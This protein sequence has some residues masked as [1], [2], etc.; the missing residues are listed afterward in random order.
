MRKI[1]DK[2]L[3]RILCALLSILVVD[4]LWQVASRYILA[5]PSSVT[6]EIAGFLLVWVGLFGAAYC[7]GQGEHLA[8]DIL[9][10]YISDKMKRRLD[11]FINVVVML[12]ALT[13]MT[14][15]GVWL[16]YTR[17]SLGVTS[18][19]LMLNLG[20]V[21]AVLPLSGVLTIYFA[22]H[23]ILRFIKESFNTK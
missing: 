13:V 1:I 20:Y 3:E 21:Y 10:Q 16:V 5:D 2:W 9:Q 19:A 18:P 17:F 6:D 15:G 22:S 11:Y 14:I 7:F 12:F 23:N 4:V 8:V